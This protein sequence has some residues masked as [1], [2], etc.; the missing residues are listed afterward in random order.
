MA[1]TVYVFY[2]S[3]YI[4]ICS[5]DVIDDDFDRLYLFFFHFGI[6]DLPS[7]NFFHRNENLYLLFYPRFRLDFIMF[8]VFKCIV[9]PFGVKI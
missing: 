3:K 6:G 4:A 8:L 2:H 1:Q 7:C 5:S 9:I